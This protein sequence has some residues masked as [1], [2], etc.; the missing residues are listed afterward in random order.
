MYRMISD[1]PLTRA[2]IKDRMYD[3]NYNPD[4]E[5]I[6]IDLLTDIPEIM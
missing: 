6:S 3:Q 5:T 2:W 4:L 1:T